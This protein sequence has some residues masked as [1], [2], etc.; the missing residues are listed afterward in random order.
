MN[1]D[2]GQISA[3][4][5]TGTWDFSF[6]AGEIDPQGKAR[7]VNVGIRTS[8]QFDLLTQSDIKT[9]FL[10]SSARNIPS[11]NLVAGDVFYVL[12]NQGNDAKVFVVRN[13]AGTMTVNCVNYQSQSAPP[14]APTITA[15]L[16]NSSLIAGGLPNY[17]IAPSSLFIVRGTGLAD[18]GV[19]TLQSSAP[20]G[21]PLTLNGASITVIVSGVDAPGDLLHQS[22]ASRSSDAREYPRGNRHAHDEL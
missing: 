2:N 8:A 3:V 18:P 20:P 16:N 4:A 5:G 1:L 9:R 15:V 17:G 21:L 7:V 6:T 10:A 12:T 14:G 22:N 11:A 19:P 13:S